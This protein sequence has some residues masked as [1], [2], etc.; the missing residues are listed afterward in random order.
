MFVKI[1]FQLVNPFLANVHSTVS[2][3]KY[4]YMYSMTPK[5]FISFLTFEYQK[6]IE[7]YAGFKSVEIIR[8]KCT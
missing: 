7:F 8:K 5:I 4:S 2:K 3:K 6:N 1:F